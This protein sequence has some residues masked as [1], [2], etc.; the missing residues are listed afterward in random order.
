MGNYSFTPKFKKYI[1]PTFQENCISEVVRIIVSIS[2][3]HLSKL[4]RANWFSYCVM[5]LFLVKLQEKFEIEI[6]HSWE[7]MD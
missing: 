1:L 4:W 6:D 2:I 3:F 7:W 5:L